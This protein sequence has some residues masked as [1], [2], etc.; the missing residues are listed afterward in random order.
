VLKE[1]FFV[2]KNKLIVVRKM[3]GLSIKVVAERCDRLEVWICNCYVNDEPFDQRQSDDAWAT[4]QSMIMD[5][6]IEHGEAV[7]E[8]EDAPRLNI[9]T[10]LTAIATSIAVP[11][12]ML[13]A[14]FAG[15]VN[16][17]TSLV[18]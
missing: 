10:I 7:V 5:A 6:T 3:P 17:S 16:F 11:G 15:V 9:A 2:T 1:T 14:H 18:V 12:L 13:A 8:C 4:A